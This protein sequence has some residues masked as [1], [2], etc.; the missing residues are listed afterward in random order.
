[1]AKINRHIE[2]VRSTA[3]GLS[4]LSRVSA[5]A[6]CTVLL[7]HYSNV[8]ISIINNLDDLEALVSQ[9][10]DLVFLGMK[11]LRD[12]QSNKIWIS[13]YLDECDIEHTG[14]S[15]AA[16]MSEYDKPTA[17][18]RVVAA[19][20]K[21]ASFCEISHG[22]ALPADLLLQFPVFVKPSN[23]GGG[24]GID[25]DSVARNSAQLQHKVTAL[26]DSYA[27]DVLIESYLPGRE[28]SAAVLRQSDSLVYSVMPIELVATVNDRGDRLLSQRMKSSNQETAVAVI[29][30][31]LKS[32]LT[33]L[34]LGA[35]EALGGRDYGRIDIRL[36]GNGVPHFLEAN[37]IP[38]LIDGYGS[39]PKA[40]WLNAGLDYETM[41]LRIVALAG[42][43][44]DDDAARAQDAFG[45]TSRHFKLFEPIGN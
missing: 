1:M 13:N 10:P 7:R 20:L 4:S 31:R 14:S 6:L 11:Y 44:L 30:P 38:S 42:E 29:D 8:S 43:R 36:D 15:Y 45:A 23:K 28:F 2:I 18:R 9:R 24:Q 19:G 34:A 35:F 33:E 16:V 3:P 40:C 39:F 21:T 12:A 25:A 32:V 37:L 26:F 22:S 17:K 41:V 5:D 27:S